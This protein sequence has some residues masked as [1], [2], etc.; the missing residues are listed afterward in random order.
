MAKNKIQIDVMV[1]GKM[2]KATISAK[3]LKKALDGAT[4]SQEQLNTSTRRGYRAAQG[5]AQNTANSTKAFSKQ[6]G[7][8]GG[9]VPIYATFAANVFAVSAAFGILSRNAA[10][11][12]LET[13]LDAIGIAAGKNLPLVAQNLRDITGQAISTEQALRATAVA[14]TSGFSTSQ[15]QNLTKV[16]TGASIALGRNLP[17][18][19]DRLVRGTAKLEP[20]ILDELGII[21][22]LDQ[23]TREYAATLNKS[24]KDL[25]QFERQ[26]AFLTATIE[27]GLNKYQKIAQAVSP[28][29]YDR[30]SSAFDNLTK[31]ALGFVNK[32][33]TPIVE[34]LSSNPMGLIGVLTLLGSTVARQILPALSDMA[35]SA[36]GTFEAFSKEAKKAKEA[37]ISEFDQLAKK[38]ET[39][40]LTP[41]GAKTIIETKGVSDLEEKDFKAI[42]K[43]YNLSIKAREANIE[44]LK[45]VEKSLRG[46]QKA[47]SQAYIREK[48]AEI[49]AI[50][51]ERDELLALATADRNSRQLSATDRNTEVFGN[52]AGAEA[53]ALEQV[54][55]A[56]LQGGFKGLT[57]S[58]QAAAAGARNAFSEV[59][60]AAG[61]AGRLSAGFRAAAT[62]VRLF[63][64]AI[65]TSLPFIGQVIF[66]SSLLLEALMSLD[67]FKKSEIDKAVD[68]A[69]SSL[70]NVTKII[71]TFRKE[72]AATENEVTRLYR[73]MQV[74]AGIT[75]QTAQAF[76]TLQNDVE[77]V[78]MQ[79]LDEQI[80][81]LIAAEDKL[82]NIESAG[83][84]TMA[85]GAPEEALT[86]MSDMAASIEGVESARTKIEELLDA[87]GTV[88]KN[89]ALKILMKQIAVLRNS[90]AFKVF[91]EMQ[92]QYEDLLNGVKKGPERVGLDD[93]VKTIE[94]NTEKYRELETGIKSAGEAQQRFDAEVSKLEAKDRTR[95]SGAI[96]NAQ[97]YQRELEKVIAILNEAKRQGGLEDPVGSYIS[98]VADSTG[99]FNRKSTT[100][101]LPM[102]KDPGITVE[103][104]EQTRPGSKAQARFLEERL[105]LSKESI[106]YATQLN[107]RQKQYSQALIKSEDALVRQK[108]LLTEQQD[109]LG[110]INDIASQGAGFA[111]LQIDQEKNVVDQKKQTLELQKRLNELL[112]S[113]EAAKLA[114]TALEA[115]I[116]A[117]EANRTNEA[118]ERYRVEVDKIGLLQLELDL[119]NKQLEAENKRF[120][121]SQKRLENENRQAERIRGTNRF[122]G[123][124]EQKAS[125]QARITVLE[126]EIAQ[127]ETLLEAEVAATQAKVAIEYMLLDAKYEYL[128]AE[129]RQLGIR[130]TESAANREYEKGEKGRKAKEKATADAKAQSDALEKVAK[131]YDDIRKKTGASSLGFDQEGNITGIENAGAVI[132]QTFQN[133]ENEAGENIRSLKQDLLDLKQEMLDMDT[134][135]MAFDAVADSLQSGLGTAITDIIDGTKSAKQ[136][137]G[138]LAISVLESFRKVLIDELTSQFFQ[139]L[140]GQTGE[141]GFLSFLGPLFTRESADTQPA[142]TTVAPPAYTPNYSSEGIDALIN[143]SAAPGFAQT[144]MAAGLGGVGGMGGAG[145]DGMGLGASAANPLFV[146][147][148]ADPM[149]GMG[150]IGQQGSS[151]V[152]GMP[153]IPGGEG[154]DKNQNK[155]TEA[156]EKNTAETIKNNINTASLVTGGLATIAAMT[157]N[158]KAAEKLAMITAALQSVQAL[159]FIFQKAKMVPEILSNIG[160]LVLNTLALNANTAASVVPVG[161]TGG[162]MSNG[163]KLKGYSNGG[164]SRGNQT[165][166]PVLLHGTEAVVPLPNG[167]S[168]PVE[169]S[170]GGS[171]VSTNNVSVNV[172][173][174]DSETS[175][176]TDSDSSQSA[177]LGKRIAQAVQQELSNQ[178]RAGG[179][180]SPYGVA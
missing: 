98:E 167:R 83:N 176:S 130:A 123:R 119:I 76:A 170:G 124:E 135:S 28:N 175:T 145:V 172:M 8:V 9:L 163:A 11:K 44:R 129:A 67:I 20:E 42:D 80:E 52:I 40:D 139:M 165:G 133:I 25:T 63:G 146:T 103:D 111:Q 94:D 86:Y 27:Q 106:V 10:I 120:E 148:V 180:L 171:S 51:R 115:E 23:A 92:Q 116:A 128:A 1:N 21:V 18:A 104:L 131:K 138:D 90:K 81:K 35:E 4:D 142:T 122:A 53:T 121:L 66:F 166:Y 91:P 132:T 48:E 127:R 65:L 117:L 70:T 34:F 3:K 12:Q 6:A 36:K 164:V 155:N 37:A 17:D 174:N 82:S 41:K 177:E 88:E 85:F 160:A 101:N 57:E 69:G 141:D 49:E 39:T 54:E 173:M 68:K 71:V 84:T 19:L 110:R 159:I 13:S 87:F 136:A 126:N 97:A 154:E 102:T 50:Q 30:L 112:M 43:S 5:T 29:P 64:A 79:N 118:K 16:A 96:D 107:D 47:A 46:Q 161:R 113:E 95:F 153:E 137:F 169:L 109:I 2:E 158:Q 179:L 45:E 60:S 114:N 149:S 32:I 100:D 178:K 140:K 157:G 125:L 143:E 144:A 150:G 58:L 38:V 89:D 105:K 162:V 26:Q 72:M 22:R 147:M 31:S 15:L 93:L 152:P 14:T 74:I 134:L 55:A 75:D 99:L 151:A 7:V 62:S 77:K 108:A 24:A 73:S 59:G 78:Q 56:G 168:I 61:A 33:T 156:I